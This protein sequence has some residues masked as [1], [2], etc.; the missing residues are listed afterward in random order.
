MRIFLFHQGNAEKTVQSLESI[1]EQDYPYKKIFVVLLKKDQLE[2]L[3]FDENISYI[4]SKNFPNVLVNSTDAY[5]QFI[6]NGDKLTK[7]RLTHMVELAN[8]S[9]EF[10]AA[11]SEFKIESEPDPKPGFLKVM[12]PKRGVPFPDNGIEQIDGKS[13]MS[14]LSKN[15][16]SIQHGISRAFFNQKI[17]N[18]PKPIENWIIDGQI[19]ERQLILWNLLVGFKIGFLDENLLEPCKEF[20]S[21]DGLKIFYELAKKFE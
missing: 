19:L 9:Y 13:L 2:N 3:P 7:D 18:D 8:S 14:Y 10:D 6:C 15:V 16:L 1:L 4:E 11:F 12:Y 21:D 20:W 5:V 17:F